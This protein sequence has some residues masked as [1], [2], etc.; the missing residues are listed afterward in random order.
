VPNRRDSTARRLWTHVVSISSRR[1][2]DPHDNHDPSD[3]KIVILGT[4]RWID[5]TPTDTDPMS[6]EEA[7][8]VT[9]NTERRARTTIGRAHS[10]RPIGISLADR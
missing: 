3:L 1:P 5:C 8:E 7:P 2:A 10:P 6:Q 4:H 9:T